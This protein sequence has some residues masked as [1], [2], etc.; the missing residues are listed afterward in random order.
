MVKIFLVLIFFTGA[1]SK[2]ESRKVISREAVLELAEE[3]LVAHY[4][5]K[6][7]EQTPF[8]ITETDE[9]WIIR[10]TLHCS[11]GAVC[12]GGVAK[13]RYNKF[14]AKLERIMHSK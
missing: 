9:S 7:L 1:C 5:K 14:S 6:V 8:V 3:D 4:G 11:S 2:R 10:G 13:V 12:K